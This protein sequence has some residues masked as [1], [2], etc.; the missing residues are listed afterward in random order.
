MCFSYYFN[1]V[2]ADPLSDPCGLTGPGKELFFR[3]LSRLVTTENTQV[4]ITQKSRFR[5]NFLRQPRCAGPFLLF[6]SRSPC[7]RAPCPA[8]MTP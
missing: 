8:G 7:C 6:L 2:L 3:P 1:F 5:A 4:K